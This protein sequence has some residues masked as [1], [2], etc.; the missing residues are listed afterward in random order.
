[1]SQ[2]EKTSEA[3]ERNARDTSEAEFN[4]DSTPVSRT[5]PSSSGEVVGEEEGEI[6][7][8]IDTRPVDSQGYRTPPTDD[9]ETIVPSPSGGAETGQHVGSSSSGAAALEA[10]SAERE[11]PYHKARRE[12]KLVGQR[13][14]G[15]KEEEG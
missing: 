5:A 12:G 1:M 8:D 11:D 4:G 9:G 13:R 7:P 3:R 15:E 10:G 2:D 6:A 14:G